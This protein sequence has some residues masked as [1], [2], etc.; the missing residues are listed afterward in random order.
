MKK[1]L[2]LAVLFIAISMSGQTV[3]LTGNF[4]G[5]AENPTNMLFATTNNINYTLNNFVLNVGSEVKFTNGTWGSSVGCSGACFPSGT[6]TGAG[7]NIAVPAGNYTVTF[8]NTTKAYSFTAAIFNTLNITG[9]AVG[10]TPIILQTSDGVSYSARAIELLTGNLLLNQTAPSAITWSGTAFPAGTAVA[11]TAGIPVVAGKYNLAFNRTTGAYSFSPVIFTLIG[12]GVGGWDNASERL[13]TTTNGVN[14]SLA[15]VTIAVNGGNADV[16]F[17]ENNDWLFQ[18][19]NPAWPTG[20]GAGTG[21]DPNIVA[22]PGT[23]SVTLNRMTRAYAFTVLSN[24]NF[25]KYN[26]D[27]YPNPTN[28]V[29]NFR[30]VTN[31]LN[32]IS[33]VDALGKTVINITPNS[34]ETTINASSLSSGVY[35]ARVTSDNKTQTV[36]L[37]KN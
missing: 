25:V 29:W 37:V 13:L 28:N 33:V 12:S 32:A 34:L 8:N 22:V 1:L 14:Y 16:K 10:A 31:V 23:Y 27:F 21:N 20:T 18:I 6:G 26:F 35:F 17:R 19:G 3:A 9:T 2:L 30:S 24:D 11:G 4:A 15:S 5:W 7:A 36:K